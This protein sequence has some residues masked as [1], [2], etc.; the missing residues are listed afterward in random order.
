VAVPRWVYPLAARISAAQAQAH[1]AA[2][3]SHAKARRLAHGLRGVLT[4]ASGHIA[5]RTKTRYDAPAWRSR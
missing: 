3:G 1:E 5:A 2:K 4:L